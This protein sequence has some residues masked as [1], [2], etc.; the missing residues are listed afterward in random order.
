MPKDKTPEKMGELPTFY[1]RLNRA[2]TEAEFNDALFG[3]GERPRGL[4]AHGFSDAEQR[5]MR[6][7]AG[8]ED[9]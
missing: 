5:K 6:R 9:R 7:A 1:K 3:T 2:G 8:S 4:G